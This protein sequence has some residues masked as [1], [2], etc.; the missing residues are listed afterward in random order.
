MHISTDLCVSKEWME[1][2]HVVQPPIGMYQ[3]IVSLCVKEM[4]N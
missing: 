1:N 2:R 3:K 4:E